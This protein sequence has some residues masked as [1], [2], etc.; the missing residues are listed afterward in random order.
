MKEILKIENLAVSFDTHSGEVSAVR[1]V[2]LVVN[3]GEILALVGES[4][5]GKSVT[6]QTIMKLNPMPPA[7]IKQ[8][9]IFL[10]ESDIVAASDKE[11]Q[12]I[13]GKVVSIVFQDPMTCLNPTMKIGRQLTEALK[14]SEKLSREECNKEAIRLLELVQ[15]P[16]AP[17]RINQYPHQFSGGMRQRVMIAM[18]LACKPK[19]LIADEPTTS[20]DVTIQAQILLLLKKI[21]EETGTAI[22]LITHDLGVVA[23]IADR[24]AVMYAGT[25]AEQ[26]D[27]KDIFSHAAHPYT[28]ALLQSMPK[29]DTDKSHPLV[30]IPGSPPSLY[31]PPGGCAFSDRCTKCM[32]QCEQQP[33]TYLVSQNHTASCWQLQKDFPLKK[34]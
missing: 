4:G 1:G 34:E 26:G 13:R 15:I 18:A 19:L 8:G 7:R 12:S 28:K 29:P 30:T 11:M 31:A 14:K 5:C 27:L 23:N 2:S 6:A 16:N 32:Q 24:V 10:C 33:P 9:G 22:L 20:L 17:L 21:R 3:S 25:I